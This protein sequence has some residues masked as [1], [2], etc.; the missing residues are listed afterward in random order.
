[1]STKDELGDF[2]PIVQKLDTRAAD[3]KDPKAEDIKQFLQA[4][5]SQSE[6]ID[7]SFQQLMQ[8]GGAMYLL[9]THY[10]IIKTLLSNPEAYAS[11]V[12]ETFCPEMTE[13]KQNPTI[14]GMKTLITKTCTASFRTRAHPS[15][16][17]AKRNLLALLESDSEEKEEE[18][19]NQERQPKWGNTNLDK[20]NKKQQKEAHKEKDKTQI[21]KWKKPKSAFETDSEEKEEETENEEEEQTQE[22]TTN[23]KKRNREEE[24]E[25]EREEK[26]KRKDNKTKKPKKVV[27]EQDDKQEQH[28]KPKEEE[29][30]LKK[31]K[32]SKKSKKD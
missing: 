9:G 27:E 11:L 30:K 28:E 3:Q 4:I 25:S 20:R 13:F 31:P 6:E 24:T 29:S 16:H 32:K 8:L 15:T 12:L 2:L 1:M 22:T 7:N 17:A 26:P 18:G 19:Q 10:T 21:N 23:P 5:L 14:K